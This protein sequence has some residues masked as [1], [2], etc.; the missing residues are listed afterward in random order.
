MDRS[1]T[2]IPMTHSSH[3]CFHLFTRGCLLAPCRR[4]DLRMG[5]TVGWSLRLFEEQQERF[6]ELGKEKLL[7]IWSHTDSQPPC[8]FTETIS[9]GW[10]RVGHYFIE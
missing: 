5:S 2:Q 8:G 10:G 9:Q 4:V 1:H 3:A 7:G 6:R